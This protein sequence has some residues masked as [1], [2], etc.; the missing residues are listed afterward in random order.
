M[1]K[2][3]IY[4][5]FHSL[6]RTQYALPG[7]AFIL[8]FTFMAIGTISDR[9]NAAFADSYT[10]YSATGTRTP[11]RAG[12]SVQPD[13]NPK[14]AGTPVSATTVA[15]TTTSAKSSVIAAPAPKP[16][17]APV[18]A[19]APSG[20]TYPLHTGIKTT[21]FWTGEAASADNDFI[22]NVS[23]AWQSDWASYFGGEDNPYSRCGYN[24]CAVAPKEN[25]F[26]FALPF[27]DFTETGIAS[28]VN[29]VYWHNAAAQARLNNGQSILKN[30]WIQVNLGAKTVYAQWQ[31]VGPFNSNDSNYVFGSAAPQSTRAGL[32]VSPAVSDYLGM[33][34]SAT[35]SWRFVTDAEVP[36]GP[37]KTT[38][39]TSGTDWN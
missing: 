20:W 38:V 27:G 35:T 37:W 7:M 28:G 24:P 25:P 23:S 36:A 10:T 17:P 14:S 34:G 32:D 29:A 13:K 22:Q 9:Q 11:S 21:Y 12:G 30:R 26:Y 3:K 39:T 8:A 18:P 6:V 19:P 31:D 1:L 33:G 5:L 4:Q 16:A 15:P 2:P